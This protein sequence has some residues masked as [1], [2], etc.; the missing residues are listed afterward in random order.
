MPCVL[1]HSPLP[2]AA[3]VRLVHRDATTV[4]LL[5]L[6]QLE[7]AHRLH[8]VRIL[9]DRGR[10]KPGGTDARPALVALE[11]HT[12]AFPVDFALQLAR[13][14]L[15]ALLPAHRTGR[16]AALRA[17][18][19]HAVVVI[20]PLEKLRTVHVHAAEFSNRISAA[21][22]PKRTLKRSERVA[23]AGHFLHTLTIGSSRRQSKTGTPPRPA[24]ADR[25]RTFCH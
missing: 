23:E 7:P 14:Q 13:R 2:R 15:L 16:A 25:C 8:A 5:L 24:R 11:A 9:L 21:I 17:V 12:L 22:E 19:A 20:E 18:L 6:E 4:H 1:T 3:A 10:I